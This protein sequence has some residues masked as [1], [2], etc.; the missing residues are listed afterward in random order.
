MPERGRMTQGARPNPGRFLRDQT[1][2][3]PSRATLTT[4]EVLDAAVARLARR[5]GKL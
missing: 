5:A 4:G 1:Q 2:P 3:G